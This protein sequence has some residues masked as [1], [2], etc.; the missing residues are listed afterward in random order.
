[1]RIL[2]TGG[3]GYIGSVVVELLL[4]RGD[5]VVVLD[6]LW[7]GHAGAVPADARLLPVDLRDREAVREAVAVASP[8]AVMHFAA[9]TI[10]PESVADPA[11]YFAANT[12][13]SHNLLSAMRETGVTRFVFSS[14]A[15]VYGIPA[16]IPVAEDAPVQ[17]INPYGLS[18]LMVEQMLDWHAAA[19]GL[20]Y[21]AFRYFNVAGATDAHGEHH[22]PE[23]HVIPVALQTLLG[24]SDVF[25]VFGT[26]Y[27][28]ADG[29]A[30]RDYVHVVD[31]A[32]AHLL[33][34]DKLDAG[35]GALNL[36]SRDG[37]SV[38]Q[39]VAAVEAVTGRTLPIEYCPR[40]E[41]D[42]PALIADASRAEKL[43]GW[44]PKRSLEEMIASS[45]EWKQRNPEGYRG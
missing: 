13:G 30:I 21:V 42:P 35:L 38:K 33:A 25:K 3:A 43:L 32:E 24:R 29:T 7:R 23:T 5:H 26:D 22:T 16:S 9:A 40:R 10:V 15:A 4:A 37:Y 36:G 8:D 17:P 28:T 39:V 1:M 34:L 19:Y 41:G 45:W 14:T 27:P 12:V 31:L 18:K 6:N 44:T 11:A 20:A 2:V